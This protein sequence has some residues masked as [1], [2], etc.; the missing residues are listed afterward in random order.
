MVDMNE[1]F[2]GLSLLFSGN[3]ADKLL[4]AFNLYDESGD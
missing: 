4:I 2:G 1:L 3:I